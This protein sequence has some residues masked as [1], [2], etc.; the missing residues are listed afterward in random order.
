MSRKN[1][2]HYLIL[3]GVSLGALGLAACTSVNEDSVEQNDW[4]VAVDD[5][6]EEPTP[7]VAVTET[8]TV[9]IDD[10]DT[11]TEACQDY[12]A[13]QFLTDTVV[14]EDI[15]LSRRASQ[16]G[17]SIKDKKKAVIRTVDK[18][19]KTEGDTTITTVK[20][21]LVPADKATKQAA[22]NTTADVM[23]EA[24]AAAATTGV[25]T[26]TRVPLKKV[27][28]TISETTTRIKTEAKTHDVKMGETLSERIEYGDTSHDWDATAGSTLRTLLMDWGNR[29]GWT[30]IWKLDRDYHL[31]AGVI[32]RGTFTE[33]SG[34]LVRSFARATPA[35]IA[36]FY[37]GN[38]V[39][40]INTQEDENER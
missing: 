25:V 30:V 9:A 6:A 5:I 32:F 18:T 20:K 35:P 17:T 8:D 29:G 39:L 33:A 4:F 26:D 11:T 40:V 12:L 24:V 13:S 36:T 37:Q 14:D 15:A 27:R 28:T 2:W 21:E 38:R 1:T 19:V 31:E 34:A 22:A 3:L 16:R 10:C 23:A 7:A